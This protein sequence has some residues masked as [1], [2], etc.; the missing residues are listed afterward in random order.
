[1]IDNSDTGV[2][3]RAYILDVT[4]L[5]NTILKPVF[6]DETKHSIVRHKMEL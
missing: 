6:Q 4:V 2:P 5:E 3:H 1:M